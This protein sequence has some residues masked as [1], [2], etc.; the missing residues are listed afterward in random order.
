MRIPLNL[1]A[2]VTADKTGAA[3]VDES[4]LPTAITA[5]IPS[6]LTP[7]VANKAAVLGSYL[8]HL[9]SNSGDITGT[10]ALTEIADHTQQR[11]QNYQ[12]SASREHYSLMAGKR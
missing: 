9:W 3:V 1:T 6:P 5:E 4:C 11:C 7:K 12:S 2:R 10:R 8:C